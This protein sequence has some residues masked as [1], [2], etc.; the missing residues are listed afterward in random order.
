[1]YRDVVESVCGEE[2]TFLA[3][4]PEKSPLYE[5][6]GFVRCMHERYD[7][8]PCLVRNRSS[9]VFCKGSGKGCGQRLQPDD[10]E[11]WTCSRCSMRNFESNL[12]RCL[13]CNEA[14]ATTRTLES[15]QSPK[16]VPK[17]AG[18]RSSCPVPLRPIDPSVCMAL[19][20]R[21]RLQRVAMVHKH[22]YREFHIF[23][24]EYGRDLF[25]PTYSGRFYPAPF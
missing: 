3:D 1:M 18:V 14:Q 25:P 7:G 23:H 12:H 5:T 11:Y 6:N 4:K 16:C 21:A 15:A 24:I 8:T 10:T 19:R 13:N 9:N 17:F 22:S 20:Q 2:P